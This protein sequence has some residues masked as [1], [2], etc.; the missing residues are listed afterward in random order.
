M[1]RYIIITLAVL[2]LL[3][4]LPVASAQTTAA[5]S[6]TCGE[7]LVWTAEDGTLTI[8]GHG[9]MTNFTIGD[10]PWADYNDTP[11]EDD[12]SFNNEG[13]LRVI[14]QPGV[15]SI[16]D[17]AFW[18]CR[19]LTEVSIP[20]TVT[21]IG[22]GAFG[23]CV[24]LPQLD[25]PESLTEIGKC[26]FQACRKVAEFTV[27]EGVSVIPEAAF[28]LCET[29]TTIQ[30]P[31]SLRRIEANA[32]TQCTSLSEITIPAGVEYIGSYAFG[33]SFNLKTVTFTGDAPETGTG[34]FGYALNE[35]VDG[36]TAPTAYYPAGNP[37][38]TQAV[39]ASF[40][41]YTTWVAYQAGPFA[42]VPSGAYY[43]QAVT[44]ALDRGI[45]EGIGNG[46]FAPDEV[47]TRAQIVTFL[48]RAAG[49][50]GYEAESCPFTD[51]PAEA[52]YYDAVMWAVEKGI[53]IGTSETT[54]SPEDTCTRAQIVTLLWR[55]Q[56]CPIPA[57]GENPF[58]DVAADAY[59]AVPVLWAVE[60]GI[61]N[62]ISEITF[63]PD[64]PCTR[65]QIVTFLHRAQ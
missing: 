46:L 32:F 62:G 30:L 55:S 31:E 52:Y 15:T 64:D 57:G 41:G 43:T 51:I 59:Y 36:T 20:D 39:M 3:M 19:G 16:G 47:C 53:T 21:Y 28:G 10:A 18:F 45:T 44:W 25:L 65:A 61:T 2:L 14:I 34:P 63:A 4:Q 7:D 37:T 6:G 49:C 54:F 17:Y 5:V 38:W 48:Y 58:A 56:G 35:Y 27:P 40:G 23:Q 50:P 29:I 60:K 9:P 26:A 33:S 1:K 11:T 13:I 24:I 12:P 8:S 22:E 42:D